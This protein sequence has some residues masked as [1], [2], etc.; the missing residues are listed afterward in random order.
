M[1]SQTSRKTNEIPDCTKRRL[2]VQKTS[3]VWNEN[4]S[5]KLTFPAFFQVTRESRFGC[6]RIARVISSEELGT[7]SKNNLRRITLVRGPIWGIL[8]LTLIISCVKSLFTIIPLQLALQSTET[9]IQQSTVKLP[10]PTEDWLNLCLSSTYFQYNG[11][12][13]KHLHGVACFG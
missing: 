6:P 1:N 3:P 12:Y 7:M 13:Y 2:R 11:K 10:L 5:Y 9:A 8:S 4:K